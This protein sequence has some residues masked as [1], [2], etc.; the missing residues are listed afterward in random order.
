MLPELTSVV[1][2]VVV[3]RFIWSVIGGM[4]NTPDWADSEKNGQNVRLRQ[5]SYSHLTQRDI[6]GLEK[7]KRALSK[8]R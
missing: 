6:Q 7:L 4:I 3:V 5:N 1:V 8:R 2:I